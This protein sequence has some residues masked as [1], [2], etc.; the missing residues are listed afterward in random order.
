MSYELKMHTAVHYLDR[1]N[2]SLQHAST[3]DNFAGAQAW[4]TPLQALGVLSTALDRIAALGDEDGLSGLL[5]AAQ[6]LE[7]RIKAG[8]YQQARDLA[9]AIE[10][11]GSTGT[12]TID[13]LINH[14]A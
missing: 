2:D 1:F 11:A 12:S 6:E 3:Y 7:S 9:T 10:L 8:R 4:L 13:A 5:T 14:N